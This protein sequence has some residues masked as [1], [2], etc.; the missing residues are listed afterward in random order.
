MHVAVH[1]ADERIVV[2]LSRREDFGHDNLISNLTTDE[3]YRQ[4]T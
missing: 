1:N 2:G 3:E 4:F